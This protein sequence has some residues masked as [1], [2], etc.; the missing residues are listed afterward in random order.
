MR[1][2]APNQMSDKTTGKWIRNHISL[3][4]WVVRIIVGLTFTV[5]GFVKAIDPWGTLYKVDDYLAAMSLSIWPNLELVGVFSLN[6]AEFLLGVFILLGCFRRTSALFLVAFMCVML[7]L[8]LWIAIFNP[9]SDC[10]C[11]GDAFKISNWATFWKNVGLSLCAVW[12]V[13][14][15]RSGHWLVTPAL[16]WIA[17][18]VSSLFIVFI[19]LYGFNYQPMLDFRPY[20]TGTTLVN[21]PES[22]SGEPIFKFLYQ[23]NGET[24][25]FGENDEL[26]SEDDGWEFVDRVEVSEKSGQ[27]TDSQKKKNIRIWSHDGEDDVTEEAIIENGGEIIVMMPELAKV[28]PAT[29]WKLNSLNEWATKHDVIMIGVVSGSNDEIEQWEDISMA[30]YPVYTADDTDIKEVVRGNPGVVYLKDGVVVWKSTLSALHIDDFMSP[31]I[32]DNAENFAPDHLRILRNSIYIYLILL[33]VLIFLSFT[34]LLKDF[35]IHRHHKTIHGDK[36]PRAESSS[37]DTPAQ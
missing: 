25:E 5:S 21:D 18:V 14:H 7:P 4:T 24:R 31:E 32:S 16:Q 23:K 26:P 9:V 36:A 29:T 13:R 6:A 10:G 3:I 20:T 33:S 19:E 35:F 30:S 27:T 11:F 34:P 15:N 8:T 37:H 28:S 1:Q 22:N 12:L 2:N 17:F